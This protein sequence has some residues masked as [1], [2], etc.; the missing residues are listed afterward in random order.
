[1]KDNEINVEIK[2]N[3]YIKRWILILKKLRRNAEKYESNDRRVFFYVNYMYKT[4][5]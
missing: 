2:S 5:Q 1:M 4:V 3:E